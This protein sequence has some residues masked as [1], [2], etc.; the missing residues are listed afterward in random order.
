ML[1]GVEPEVG[2]FGDVLTRGPHAEYAAGILGCA[3]ITHLALDEEVVRELAVSAGHGI[4][5][6]RRPRMGG[7]YPAG[8]AA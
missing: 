5:L 4:S 3:V 8:G 2:Q 6:C 7:S 1:Q